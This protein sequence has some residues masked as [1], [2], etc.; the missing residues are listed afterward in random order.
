MARTVQAIAPTHPGPEE[1]CPHPIGERP[2]GSGLVADLSPVC[3]YLGEDLAIKCPRS[4]C[5]RANDS[6][7]PQWRNTYDAMLCWKTCLIYE[8]INTTCPRLVP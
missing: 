2:G 3:V 4:Y 5:C 1:P 7:D 6:L 8:Q